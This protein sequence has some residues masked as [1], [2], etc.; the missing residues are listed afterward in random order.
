VDPNLR[1]KGGSMKKVVKE[2]RMPIH[3]LPDVKDFKVKV[4][5]MD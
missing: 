4:N 1:G 2:K 5:K 3:L